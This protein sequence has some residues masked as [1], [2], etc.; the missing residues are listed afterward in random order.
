VTA[1][2]VRISLFLVAKFCLVT[3]FPEALLPLRDRAAES[4]RA[5]MC[6]QAELGNKGR[7]QANDDDS[8]RVVS[9][10]CE[11]VAAVQKTLIRPSERD[12]LRLNQMCQRRGRIDLNF[13]IFARPA[14]A[15]FRVRA[16]RR[17]RCN[18]KR[19][20]KT[21][22]RPLPRLSND[23]NRDIRVTSVS[24][25]VPQWDAAAID[26]FLELERRFSDFVAV[27]NRTKCSP[28]PKWGSL[29]TSR[30]EHEFTRSARSTWKRCTSSIWNWRSDCQ[31]YH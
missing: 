31:P 4:R 9:P 5:G 12:L 2:V 17:E 24:R 18:L 29:G 8:G 30:I 3:R 6:S 27:G 7:I 14:I 16:L 15:V 13:P 21:R 19:S 26:E 1:I 10:P 25:N 22:S 23:R 20:L 11:V 28:L